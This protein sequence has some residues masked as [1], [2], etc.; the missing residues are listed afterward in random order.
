MKLIHIG[1]TYVIDVDNTVKESHSER[2]ILLHILAELKHQEKLNNERFNKYMVDQATLDASLKSLTDAVAN[3]TT[4]GVPS[5]PDATVL[6][7]VAGV[8][9]NTAHLIAGPGS[10]PPPPTP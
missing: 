9:T 2:E 1:P 6:A 5:T 4:V 10:P 8:D 7:Y 3:A